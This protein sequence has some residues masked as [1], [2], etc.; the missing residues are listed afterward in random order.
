MNRIRSATKSSTKNTVSQGEYVGPCRRGTTNKRGSKR[1]YSTRD[2][3]KVAQRPF[4]A[5]GPQIRRR[6]I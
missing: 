3:D 2:G 1:E 4:E 5:F 6:Y